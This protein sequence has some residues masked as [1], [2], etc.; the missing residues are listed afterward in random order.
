MNNEKLIEAVRE[1]EVLYDLSHSK[2]IDSTYK[3]TIWKAIG[4]DL[5]Q[6]G[7]TFQNNIIKKKYILWST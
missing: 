7:N 5:Q 6:E 1:H 4:K 2:Y 3:D